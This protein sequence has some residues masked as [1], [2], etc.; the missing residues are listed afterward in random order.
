MQ[1]ILRKMSLADYEFLVGLLNSGPSLV[2]GGVLKE[3][4]RELE[5]SHSEAAVDGLCQA[6]E[7]EIRYLGSADGAYLVRKALGQEPG[8]S[9]D[10]MIEDVGKALKIKLPS[11]CDEETK[12]TE[13]V[14]AH[15]GNH[16]A[17]LGPEKQ[18]QVLSGIGAP[19]E[20]INAFFRRSAVRISLPLL[21][22]TF[23]AGVVQKLIADLALGAIAGFLSRGVAKQLLQEVMKK[24]PLWSRWLGPAAWAVSLGWTAADLQGPAM[25]K[26]IPV[27]L[28]LGLATLRTEEVG[29]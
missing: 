24:F 16:F 21:L 4:L 27:L 26:T 3:K 1:Q 10:A 7:A 13:L 29:D 20:E 6:L 12:L 23:G 17:A 15:V 22:Q 14:K 28:Y 2:R 9:F 25:R 19:P 11:F 18:R 8:V 5:A